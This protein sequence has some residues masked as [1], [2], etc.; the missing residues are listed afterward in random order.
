MVGY[1]VD[2]VESTMHHYRK[3]VVYRVPEPLPCA[4]CRAHGKHALCRVPRR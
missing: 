2:R 1:V 3:P 4:L